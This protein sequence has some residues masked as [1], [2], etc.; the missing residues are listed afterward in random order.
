[1]KLTLNNITSGFASATATN[2]N[3]D[4]VEAAIENTLSR[5]GTGPNQMLSNLDM[6][7]HGILNVTSLVVNGVDVSTLT[8]DADA[9]AASAAA[10]LVSE[11]NADV[12]EANAAA[13]ASVIANWMWK[14]NWTDGQAYVPNNVVYY[15]TDGACYICTVAHTASGTIDGAKFAK[16]AD[17]GAAGAGTGDMLKSENLSGLANYTTARANLGLTIGTNVQAYDEELAAIAGLTSAANKL[18]YFTGSGTA[19]M[20]DWNSATTL[21][22]STTTVS[23]NTVIKSA[24]DNLIVN[25]TTATPDTAADSFVFEDATDNTQKKALLS[26]LGVLTASTAQAST[27]GTSIDFSSIPSTVKRI[28]LGLYNVG[29]NGSASLLVRLGTGGVATTTG[30]VS[31]ADQVE[32]NET[33]ASN[34]TGFIILGATGV[35]TT[36]YSGI[37]TFM[38]VSSTLWVAMGNLYREDG[39]LQNISAGRVAL[40]GDLDFLRITTTN[41]TDAF[42]SGTINI[43]YE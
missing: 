25:C 39:T 42:D 27:S 19:G 9:A 37:I 41:G 12:S 24:I 5:D 15:T 21:A 11:N 31:G 30:Y 29:T 4:L 43:L 28:T 40:S 36:N 38:R 17:R 8:D 6:N 2:T 18:P 23:S 20:L 32:D 34:T 33:G 3:N 14:S 10:A 13:S 7:G 35:S 1:M 16:L 22:D 26:S